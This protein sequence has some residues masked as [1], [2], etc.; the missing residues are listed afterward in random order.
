MSHE[1]QDGLVVLRHPENKV[2]EPLAEGGVA[3]ISE[4]Q[5]EEHSASVVPSL[6]YASERCRGEAW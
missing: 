5:I 1:F 2:V 3:R 6:L 4:D